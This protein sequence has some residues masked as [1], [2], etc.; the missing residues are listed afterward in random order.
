M[1]SCL[2]I[3]WRKRRL[4]IVKVIYLPKEISS[5]PLA[6]ELAS[7]RAVILKEK[8]PELV[9]GEYEKDGNKVLMLFNENIGNAVNTTIQI[10]GETFIY[11]YDA[12]QNQMTRLSRHIDLH[13]EPYESV[14]L[15]QSAK[16][17]ASDREE[18]LEKQEWYFLSKVSE[19]SSYGKTGIDKQ[20]ARF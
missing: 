19:S 13:L 16:E 9:V 12:F 10:P 4:R 14:V 3:I 1:I 17:L 6:K 5:Y 2:W 18:L 20:P 15:I 7:Y 8:E 11:Q